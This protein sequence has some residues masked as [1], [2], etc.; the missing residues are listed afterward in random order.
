MQNEEEVLTGGTERTETGKGKPL[1]RCS[2]I[3]KRFEGKI[4]WGKI[5]WK[6]QNHGWTESCRAKSG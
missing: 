5:M 3:Q 6:G 1:F 4:M 2:S